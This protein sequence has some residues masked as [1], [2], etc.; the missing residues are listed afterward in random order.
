MTEHQYIVLIEQMKTEYARLEEEH[1]R[2]QK[3]YAELE[4]Y[5][6]KLE[7]GVL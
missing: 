1:E 2:L 4:R 6:E 3:D 5:C 7:Q